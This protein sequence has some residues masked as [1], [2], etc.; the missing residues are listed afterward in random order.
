MADGTIIDY[1]IDGQNRRIAKKV[2][3]SIVNK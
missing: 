1:V 2:N 3:G